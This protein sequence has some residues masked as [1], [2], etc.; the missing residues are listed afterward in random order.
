MATDL[1]AGSFS[2]APSQFTKV[3]V[4]CSGL[5]EQAEAVCERPNPTKLKTVAKLTRGIQALEKALKD[6]ER[7]HGASPAE[8]LAEVGNR[9]RIAEAAINSCDELQDFIKVLTTAY[10][11]RVSRWFVSPPSAL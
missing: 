4:S 7:Q 10:D 5:V 11:A 1:Q 8:L 3:D 6:H 2:S 9:R